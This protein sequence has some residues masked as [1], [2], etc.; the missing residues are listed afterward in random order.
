MRNRHTIQKQKPPNICNEVIMYDTQ[1]YVMGYLWQPSQHHTPI[2]IHKVLSAELRDIS[3]VRHASLLLKIPNAKVVP[4]QN[5]CAE[6]R[7]SQ[8]HAIGWKC[9]GIVR[10]CAHVEHDR[11]IFVRFV[12]YIRAAFEHYLAET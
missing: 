8:A 7:E 6:R 11:I 10:A 9:K 2:R 1:K 3:P 4:K 12:D 5:A